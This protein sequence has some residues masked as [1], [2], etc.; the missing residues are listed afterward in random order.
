MHMKAG[1]DLRATL[2]EYCDRYEVL[3]HDMVEVER[4][5]NKR[6]DQ[7][8]ARTYLRTFF[9]FVEGT[10]HILKN[11]AL[12]IHARRPC[13]TDGEISI[14]KE[15]RFELDDKGQVAEKYKYLRC[16]DN[17]HF[18]FDAVLK[19]TESK[20]VI[21]YGGA[22]WKHFIKAIRIRNRITHPKSSQELNISS[23]ELK[24]VIGGSHWYGNVIKGLLVDRTGKPLD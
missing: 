9:A 15:V 14:L 7:F 21:D 1:T 2:K 8:A 24:A 23:E 22:G 13:F 3:R 19:A 20:Y 17:V 11:F 16:G 6:R 10:I 12:G 4:L 5:Y 18:G